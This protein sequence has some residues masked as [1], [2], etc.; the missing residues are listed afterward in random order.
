MILMS[1]SMIVRLARR[2][3]GNWK[4]RKNV[5]DSERFVSVLTVV[6]ILLTE[7]KQ[8]S[9]QRKQHIAVNYKEIITNKHADHNT[10][11]KK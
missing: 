4:R 7:M 5:R 6:Y 1:R 10:R 2:N 11:E 9:E 8:H 3:A